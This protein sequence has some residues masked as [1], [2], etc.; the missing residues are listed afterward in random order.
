MNKVIPPTI[1]QSL[2]Y[3]IVYIDIIQAPYETR[4]AGVHLE[5]VFLQANISLYMR[6]VYCGFNLL[7]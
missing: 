1:W 7:A 3:E 6:R 5:I 4:K 2:F